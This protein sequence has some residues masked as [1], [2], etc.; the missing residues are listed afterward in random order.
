MDNKLEGGKCCPVWRERERKEMRNEKRGNGVWWWDL[1]MPITLELQS[2][3][4]LLLSFSAP[5]SHCWM[6]PQYYWLLLCDHV[7]ALTHPPIIIPY[8]PLPIN[9]LTPFIP[10]W[11][12]WWWVIIFL[13]SFSWFTCILFS[14]LFFFFGRSHIDLGGG[15]VGVVAGARGWSFALFLSPFFFSPSTSSRVCS[16]SNINIIV[17]I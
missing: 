13:A 10:L 6:P 11:W 5:S 16:W 17:L 7:H 14:L 3:E 9:H 15:G 12:W 8:P 2:C 1:C 4:V